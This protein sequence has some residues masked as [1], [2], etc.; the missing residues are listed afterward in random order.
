M[1]DGTLLDADEAADLIPVHIDTQG[2]LNAWEQANIASALGWALYRRSADDTL[3]VEFVREL[4]R[5]MFGNT[6]KWAGRFRRSA[7][8]IGVPAARI[9]EH[10]KDLLEDVRGWI[11]AGTYGVDELAVRFHHRLVAIHPFPNGNGRHARMITDALLVSMDALPFTWGFANAGPLHNS[12]DVRA[13]YVKA[14]RDADKGD[15]A[16]LL[17]FARR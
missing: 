6:W 9:A 10:L 4:H 16:A 1:T 12:Q 13:A 14:L 15:Y 8:N 11:A 5:R 3:T 17:T 7:K 2:A